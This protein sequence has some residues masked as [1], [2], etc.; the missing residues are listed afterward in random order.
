MAF[1]GGALLV[2]IAILLLRLWYL[3]VLDGDNYLARAND[4]Q[5]R[6]VAIAA[7]RGRIE[8][9]AGRVLVDSRPANAIVLAPGRL[10][11]AGSAERERV[12]VAMSR[13]LGLPTAE[14]DCKLASGSV[15]LSPLGCRVER[16]S[17]AMPY[18]NIVIRKDASL[19]ESAWVLEH[20]RELPGADVSRVWLRTY[21]HGKVAAQLFGTI[22]EIS[23][24]QIGKPR[25]AGIKQGTVIGQSGLEYQYDRYLRGRDGAERI[26]VDAAG[27]AHRTLQRSDPV[28]GRTLRLSLDLNL[29]RV[30]QDA[31]ATAV[32]LGEGGKAAAYVAMDP[33]DGRVLALGSAPS[34][35][36]GVFAKPISERK[37]E[38]IFGK[39]AAYPQLDRAIQSAYPTGSTFKVVTALAAL[40][41]G[42]VT[43]ATT[44]N[45]EGSIKIGNLVFHNAG[46]EP[47]GVVNLRSALKVSSDVYFYRLGARM[48]T[49]DTDGGPLQNWSRQ[50]GFGRPTGIDLPGEVAGTVPTPGWRDARKRLERECAAKRRH[51]CGLSDGRPWSVGD[52]VNL[53][54]GQGDFLA[55]PVQLAVAY[56]AIATG[57][58]IV[59]PRVAQDVRNDSGFVLQAI[60]GRNPRSVAID[61][62]D[63]SAVLDGLRD[64]AMA[65][66]GTSSDVFADFGRTVFGKTG[67]AEVAGQADQAWYAMYVPDQKRPLVVVVTVE[68]G[69]F[70]AQSAAPAARLIAS[71]WFGLKGKLVT[72]HSR[73]R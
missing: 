18:A 47:N 30:G 40:E 54:V 19:A 66:G 16:E 57:G 33:R 7:P 28:P 44:V 73:T 4:N 43:P 41:D 50:L 45:D 1:V 67:T 55:T 70:G 51:P 64:A 56:S 71:R 49:T 65:P 72:G 68:R 62:E 58:T 24:E 21:P 35:D 59:E 36:P 46:N 9:R 6:D 25:F 61:A 27:K 5:I 10:P 14:R 17:A 31:L 13:A 22:G 69:G 11:P 34:F 37:Y 3:Q 32:S 63:R 20:R 48:N 29:L 38:E 53:S 52:G 23:A 26:Q 42:V 60:K 15:Q 2:L 39:D 8:D 12:A